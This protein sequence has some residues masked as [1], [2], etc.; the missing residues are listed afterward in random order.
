MA[1]LSHPPVEF[2]DDPADRFQSVSAANSHACG[3]LADQTVACWGGNSHWDFVAER[4]VDDGKLDAPAGRFLSVSVGHAY[5]CGLRVDGTVTCWGSNQHFDPEIGD[6]V[7]NG[8]AVAPAG[9]FG[10]Q[11]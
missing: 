7:E 11:G 6:F 2:A 8:R 5:S 9:T 1:D 3:V 4:V 10:S